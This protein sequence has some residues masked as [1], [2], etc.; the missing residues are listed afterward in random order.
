MV[1]AL[2]EGK[3]PEEALEAGKD[4]VARAAA[5]A[6]EEVSAERRIK[7]GRA[8]VKVGEAIG[9]GKLL[10]TVQDLAENGPSKAV[11][12]TK[13]LPYMAS[14]H[15]LESLTL[16]VAALFDSRPL[17]EVL[18]DVVRFGKDTDTNGAIAGGLLGARDGLEAI[19]LRWRE[20]L[21][22]GKEF[23]EVAD[24]LLASEGDSN[25]AA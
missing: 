1:R 10:V 21:Q 3:S 19:P 4:A 8:A 13:A 11:N 2:V 24:Y 9:A 22:F 7:M 6:A 14:G 18:I 23:T 16:A 12:A 20:K 15:V 5:A 25:P 17:E